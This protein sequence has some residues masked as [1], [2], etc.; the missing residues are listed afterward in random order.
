[1]KQRNIAFATATAFVLIACKPV[2]DN[3]AAVETVA[4]ATDDHSN[5]EQ[6]LRNKSPVIAMTPLKPIF[7]P[8]Q[9]C[10]LTWVRRSTRTPILH[11][12]KA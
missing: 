1:M 2:D 10:M 4:M 6:G 5:H 7:A 9:R 8:M 12:C 11:S 3:G